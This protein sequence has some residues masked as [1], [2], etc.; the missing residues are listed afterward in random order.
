[1]EI[2]QTCSFGVLLSVVYATKLTLT[3]TPHVLIRLA[4]RPHRTVL[5]YIALHKS[6]VSLSNVV[7]TIEKEV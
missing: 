4:F 3:C 1:M 7:S 5:G 6:F 2:G